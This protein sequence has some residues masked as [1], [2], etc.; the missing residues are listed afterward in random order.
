MGFGVGQTRSL[1][2][3]CLWASVSLYV[4]RGKGDP[5]N[6]W[7]VP[8][9]AGGRL[10]PPLLAF[11]PG[12]GPGTQEVGR[13][14]GRWREEA[15]GGLCWAVRGLSRRRRAQKH[16]CCTGSSVRLRGAG[17]GWETGRAGGGG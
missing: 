1:V 8:G 13:G 2:S 15:A 12:S 3:S 7:G 6:V 9:P 17:A 10:S 16:R 14:E 11:R 4:K 5:K